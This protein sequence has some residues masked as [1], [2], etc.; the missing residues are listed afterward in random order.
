MWKMSLE[1]VVSILNVG[2]SGIL[3]SGY[4]LGDDDMT[5]QPPE[6]LDNPILVEASLFYT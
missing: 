1:A 2:G 6:R 5:R 4:R 3:S